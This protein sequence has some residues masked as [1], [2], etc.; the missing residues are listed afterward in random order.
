[1][2]IEQVMRMETYEDEQTQIKEEKLIRDKYCIG[3]KHILGCKGK[4]RG[5]KNCVSYEDRIPYKNG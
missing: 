3:C 1:M 5:V 4:R 2:K